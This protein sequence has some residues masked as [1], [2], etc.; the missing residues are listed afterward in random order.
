M[1]VASPPT[2]GPLGILFATGLVT[3]EQCRH[4]VPASTSGKNSLFL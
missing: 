4:A 3:E 1:A 2:L